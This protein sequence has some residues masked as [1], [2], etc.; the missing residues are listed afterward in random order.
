M[1][2]IINGAN[3]HMG[4]ILRERIIEQT[5]LTLS[6]EAGIGD[7]I[8]PIGEGNFSGDIVI[9]FSS[10]QGTANLIEFCTSKSLPVV[11]ATTGQ[12]EEEVAMIHEAAKNIP[13]F[14]SANMSVG[15]ALLVE[16]A[17]Q[18]VAVFPQADIE[19]IEMHHNRK[20]DAPS[21][22]ALMIAES[23][24][25]TAPPKKLLVGRSKQGQR[26]PQEIGIHAVRI[27][28]EVGTHEVIIATENQRITLKHEAQERSLFA[29]GAIAAARFLIEKPAGL[30]DMHD[31]I[32]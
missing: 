30:Y 21:G 7:G 6:G 4:R 18:A 28:N 1:D 22:T 26:Q 14:F 11:I 24:K 13:V 29:D 32:K 10:H 27:G 23:I 2:I 31:F 9:D 20:L 12:S 8:I 5:G 25:A 17:K 3:G 19:I 16:L 15:I